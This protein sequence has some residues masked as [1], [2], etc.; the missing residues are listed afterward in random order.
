MWKRVE[1]HSKAYTLRDR[2][3]KP[4]PLLREGSSWPPIATAGCKSRPGWTAGHLSG[5]CS[6][7]GLRCVHLVP[8]AIGGRGR[9]TA[10]RAACG[11]GKGRRREMSCGT[12]VATTASKH[13]CLCNIQRQAHSC[14]AHSAKRRDTVAWL[15]PRLLNSRRRMAATFCG[16][17][18]EAEGHGAAWHMPCSAVHCALH[19]AL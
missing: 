4:S 15:M 6:N 12:S 19:S 3:G 7:R 14:G 17:W 18:W 1:R 16:S 11:W 5:V 13:A 9:Q 8:T 2:V 10:L